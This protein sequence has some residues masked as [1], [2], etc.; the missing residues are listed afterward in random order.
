MAE[1]Y[2]NIKLFIVIYV[3]FI[4]IYAIIVI[5]SFIMIVLYVFKEIYLYESKETTNFIEYKKYINNYIINNKKFF[6]VASIL[7]IILGAIFLCLVL[8]THSSYYIRI[9]LLL[10]LLIATILSYILS[11]SQKI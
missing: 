6:I 5:I 10:I 2:G 9:F 7:S 4:D 3:R 11:F 1:I 8:K